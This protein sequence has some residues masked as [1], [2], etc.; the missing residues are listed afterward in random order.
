MIGDYSG[1]QLKSGM[2]S[3]RGLALLLEKNP[4]IVDLDYLHPSLIKNEAPQWMALHNDIA[5]AS[6][7]KLPKEVITRQGRNGI[8]AAHLNLQGSYL[9]KSIFPHGLGE[10]ELL[11][12]LEASV[13]SMDTTTLD[14][15]ERLA[16][17][18]TTANF[19]ENTVAITVLID[20]KTQ[21]V[22]TAYPSGTQNSTLFGFSKSGQFPMTRH[23]V[24]R[25]SNSFA[26]IEHDL[27]ATL[28]QN[29]APHKVNSGSVSDNFESYK[30]YFESDYFGL[31]LAEV[32]SLIKADS[33]LIDAAPMVHYRRILTQML[34]SSKIT[35]A[36]KILFL[37][38]A[39]Y[40][41]RSF[42]FNPDAL[43]FNLAIHD[44]IM[45]F[46]VRSLTAEELKDFHTFYSSSPSYWYNLF[47]TSV[48]QAYIKAGRQRDL[49]TLLGLLKHPQLF[50]LSQRSVLIK[51][52]EFTNDI[53][54]EQIENPNFIEHWSTAYALRIAQL[55]LNLTRP[56]LDFV[57]D[58]LNNLFLILSSYLIADFRGAI[59]NVQASFDH[60]LIKRTLINEI[61]NEYAGIALEFGV[62]APLNIA[63]TRIYPESNT[64]ALP[65]YELVESEGKF[66]LK[67]SKKTAFRLSSAP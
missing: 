44:D 39:I 36:E 67:E 6:F 49:A 9:W 42:G 47:P 15:T 35:Q 58:R 12:A 34:D 64:I 25:L 7:V 48:L 38:K 51:P 26:V 24:T 16:T 32:A 2:H 62:S 19:K 30:N 60:D 21:T 41:I 37:K 52:L 29:L 33:F 40:Q 13:G 65:Y 18:Q 20:T 27:W 14:K 66:I 1:T 57:H 8:R 56:D 61:V 3:L 10:S 53:T 43:L 28:S 23:M 63:S 50:L 59:K 11:H 22:V 5:G 46:A 17:Y 55:N 45:K 31:P 54:H 4:Q